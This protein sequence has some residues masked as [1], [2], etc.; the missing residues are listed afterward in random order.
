MVTGGGVGTGCRAG[1]ELFLFRLSAPAMISNFPRSSMIRTIRSTKP[2]KQERPDACSPRTGGAARIVITEAYPSVRQANALRAPT[3]ASSSRRDAA[4][5]ADRSRSVIFSRKTTNPAT[6]RNLLNHRPNLDLVLVHGDP[7]F[8]R[9]EDDV[10]RW[11]PGSP[12]RSST[13]A[14]LRPLMSCRPEEQD[15]SNVVV[16]CGGETPPPATFSLRR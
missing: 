7:Q 3:L 2:S 1:V 16:S 14:W 9:L 4:A 12:A 13:L 5:T 10:F 15:F 8:A 6:Q 11:P